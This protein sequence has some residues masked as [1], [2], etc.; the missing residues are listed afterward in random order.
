MLKLDNGYAVEQ[1]KVVDV[2]QLSVEEAMFLE[3]C[4]KQTG[5]LPSRF[6]QLPL[7]QLIWSPAEKENN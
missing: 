7:M 1:R 5:F 4:Q 2:T 6:W 3:R